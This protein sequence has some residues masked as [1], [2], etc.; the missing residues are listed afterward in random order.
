MASWTTD[1]IKPRERLSFGRG[2]VCKNVFNISSE[3]PP[4]LFSGLVTAHSPGPLR[5]ATC[6]T[7]GWNSTWFNDLSHFNRSFRACFGMPP[8]QSRYESLTKR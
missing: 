5:F 3:A 1:T 6:E 8:K 7:P 4:E 2:I